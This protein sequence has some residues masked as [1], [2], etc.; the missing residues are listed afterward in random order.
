[1]AEVSL[2]LLVLK[3]GQVE[4]LLVFYRALGI[5]FVEERHAK[6]PLHYA[7]KLGEIVFE[8][9][10]VTGNDPVDATVRL[11]FGVPKLSETIAALRSIGAVYGQRRKR[12][13]MG[14]E[15]GRA[16]PG[17]TNRRTLSALAPGLWP[18]VPSPMKH[19]LVVEDEEHLAI[20]IKY[21][22]EAEGY[23]VS[24]VGDGPRRCP[25][26]RK[27]R[28]IDLVILDLMLPGMSGYAVCE[29]IRNRGVTCRC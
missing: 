13:R 3:T 25:V 16:R 11:G 29:T 28:A 18:L 14:N 27:P 6:G 20:A 22:L 4:N 26:L 23:D 8:L 24:T 12:N 1:M 17:R 15:S 21:N 9:Y 7:G 19:I 10:P 2:T 5:D